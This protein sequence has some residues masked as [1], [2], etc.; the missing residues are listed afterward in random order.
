MRD[1][2]KNLLPLWFGLIL[3][4]LFPGQ[5]AWGVTLEEL[6]RDS[7]LTPQRFAEYFK[8]FDFVFHAEVQ[9]PE[10]FLSS[11]SGDCDDFA[12]VADLILREKG[13]TPH[14]ISVR[15][16]KAIH[17][18]CYID[19]IGGYLDYNYRNAPSRTI[20][21]GKALPEIAALVSK[22]FAMPWTSASE[23]SYH[24]GV[25]RLVATVLEKPTPA[26]ALRKSYGPPKKETT[27]AGF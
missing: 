11:R 4:A 9:E 10:T 16:G 18:V 12:T 3:L 27:L 15:M 21:C 2:K 6:R 23:F 17:V 8:D 7:R 14:L 1:S 5:R 25:K 20:P 26:Y 22:S 19:E 13:Y 24:E